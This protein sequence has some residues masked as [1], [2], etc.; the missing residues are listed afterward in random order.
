[1]IVVVLL[2]VMM[3]MMMLVAYTVP[4]CCWSRLVISASHSCS[5]WTS[6]NSHS[7]VLS[8]LS[9]SSRFTAAHRLT[10]TYLAVRR[11]VVWLSVRH[12]A[13]LCSNLRLVLHICMLLSPS[14]IIWYWSKVGL[15]T[16]KIILIVNFSKIDD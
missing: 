1:M 6:I 8:C 16:I 15:V 9:D 7:S 3:M 13:L 2:L 12:Q 11:W 10:V 4:S 5:R 14:S